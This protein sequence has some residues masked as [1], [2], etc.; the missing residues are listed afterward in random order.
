MQTTEFFANFGTI[1]GLD[2]EINTHHHAKNTTPFPCLV[3][4]STIG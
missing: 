1:I 4:I 2:T 3:F